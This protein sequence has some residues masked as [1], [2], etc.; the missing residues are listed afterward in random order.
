MNFVGYQLELTSPHAREAAV[1]GLRNSA[2]SPQLVLDTCQRLECFGLGLPAHEHLR[3]IRSF[4][5][6]AAFE[7]LARIAAGLE[8]RILGELE[9]IGQVRTAYKQFHE[10]TGRSLTALDRIFQDA[11]ALA[12][13][14]RRESEIDR[15]LT[16]LSGLAAHA[17]MDR[18]PPEAPL[19]V[20][21]SGSLA[22]GVV[23]SLT[24][25]GKRPVRIAS[26]CPENALSLAMEVDGFAH[27]LDELTHLFDGAAGIITATAAPH[28]L[29]FPPHLATAQ[30]PLVIVDLGVPPD[31][32]REV[33]VMDGVT[34]ISLADIEAKAQLN[35]ADRR[36]RAEHAARL[37]HEGALTWA[38]RRRKPTHE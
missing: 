7:R 31:C 33:Q 19:A 22:T 5:S 35:S 34:Y 30:R 10:T 24:K 21:G 23:R 12:R 9:V 1:N 37:V 15:N 38:A 8:S 18:L 11:L 2:Q 17:L 36:E 25:S 29:V 4:D 14:A 28:A 6:V 26:R 16:S 27:G 32:C 13:E 3:V 20:V